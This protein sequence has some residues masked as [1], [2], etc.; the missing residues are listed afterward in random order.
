MRLRTQGRETALKALYQLD[1]RKDLDSDELL[2]LLEREAKTDAAREFASELL[3]GVRL[4]WDAL[5][6]EVEAVAHNWKLERMAVIDRN[7][8]R[9]GAFELLH[10]P[11]IPPAVAIDE[12]VT[13]AK[14]FSTKD[15]GSFVNGILDKILRRRG[16][17]PPSDTP[18]AGD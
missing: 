13:L 2:D 10:R 8:L 5:D 18:N 9:L 7:V 1:L 14:K 17:S 3:E 16:D 4:H 6:A 11:D 12:A 15:S